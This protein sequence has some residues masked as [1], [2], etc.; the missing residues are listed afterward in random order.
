MIEIDNV[1]R[2]GGTAVAVAS[3][4][5]GRSGE[6]DA[7]KRERLIGVGADIVIP[8]FQDWLP[9]VEYLWRSA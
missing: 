4:E 9:L 2:A 6:P 5:A 7:W 8:D 3:D 1:T